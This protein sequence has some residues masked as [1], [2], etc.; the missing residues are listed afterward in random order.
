MYQ[1]NYICLPANKYVH[2]VNEWRFNIYCE[3]WT[4]FIAFQTKEISG[5]KNMFILFIF[6]V[7]KFWGGKKKTKKLKLMNVFLPDIP[8]SAAHMGSFW[9]FIYLILVLLVLKNQLE[10]ATARWRSRLWCWRYQKALK[11]Q[12]FSRSHIMMA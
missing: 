2:W 1:Y 4:I 5:E 8:F 12:F 11:W 7:R 6:H 9:D 10:N 3:S